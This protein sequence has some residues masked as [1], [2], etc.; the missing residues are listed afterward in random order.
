MGNRSVN[1][2][3]RACEDKYCSIALER[4][5]WMKWSCRWL[6]KCAGCMAGNQHERGHRTACSGSADFHHMSHQRRCSTNWSFC[7]ARSHPPGVHKAGSARLDRRSEMDWRHQ[8]ERA[9]AR[10]NCDLRSNK[11]RGPGGQA[12]VRID[13]NSPE[14]VRKYTKLLFANV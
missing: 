6:C 12:H 10:E 1:T 5:A 3:A 14:L 2:G 9:N 13:V 11:F 8:K 4:W 7:A